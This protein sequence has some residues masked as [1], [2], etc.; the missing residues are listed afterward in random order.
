MVVELAP[1][2]RPLPKG[3]D[4]WTWEPRTGSG[5][6]RW[7]RVYHAGPHNRDGH[8][9][10]GYGPLYRFDP[11]QR[12]SSGAPRT[13]PDGRTVLY[14][15]I[16]LATSACEVFGEGAHAALCPNYRVAFLAPTTDLRLFDRAAPGSAMAIGALPALATGALKRT[17][18]QQ[19]ARAIYEDQPAAKPVTGI[20]YNSAYNGA[21]SL[22][23]WDSAGLVETIID[24]TGKPA[25][26]ALADARMLARF[27]AAVTP[28]LI[29]VDVINSTSCPHC[30]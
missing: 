10:R 17:L 27:T 7:C 1:P 13:D 25:D 4:T 26:I 5:P 14:V 6:W 2:V 24:R 29:T 12:D 18:T 3:G 19:W 30:P 23:L 9:P 20:A 15:G 16:D 22:A 8:T 21:M 11:H 28:R